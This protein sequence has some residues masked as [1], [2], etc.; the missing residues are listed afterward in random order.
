LL[1]NFSSKVED[2]S[3]EEDMSNIYEF[4]AVIK[5]APDMD[6]AYIEIP[7]PLPYYR[8]S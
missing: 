7:F 1:I 8:N 6:A 4:E 2:I 3:K 5:K